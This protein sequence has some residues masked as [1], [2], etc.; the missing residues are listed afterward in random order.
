VKRLVVLAG[1]WAAAT[2]QAAYEPL[3]MPDPSRRWAVTLHTRGEFD[4]NINTAP[5]NERSSWKGVVEPELRVN[6]PLDQT[7]VGFRYG[8]RAVYFEN[9][10]GDP[11]D[12]EHRT[13]L[14]LAHTINPRLQLDLREQLR[15]GIEPELVEQRAAGDQLFRRRQG[16]YLYNSLEG[17]VSYNFTRRWTAALRGGWDHWDYE[18]TQ[19]SINDR[20]IYR[21]SLAMN[22]SID[23]RTTAGVGYQFYHVDYDVPGPNDRRN[24]DAHIAYLSAVRRFNPQLSGQANVGVELREFGDGASDIGPWLDTSLTYNYGPQ[25]AAT[26]GFRYSITSTEVGTFRSADSADIL[27]Q[28]THRLTAKWVV[29]GT[30]TF[31]L[32]H[33][34]NPVVPGVSEDLTEETLSLAVSTRYQ[35]TRWLSADLRYS[36]DQVTSDIA[37][38]E[39]TRNRISLGCRL[40]Y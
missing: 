33:F 25:S 11:V 6:V 24:S 28:I 31:S 21:G 37:G 36:F 14:T 13:D 10:S 32:D 2:T 19:A 29:S 4:D 15:L 23:R 3:K 38:R 20:D 8:Y 35:F 5:S 22:Y 40:V 27:V 1:L 18:E 17:G 9:R 39:F 34:S 7:F 16:D 26:L 30:S 12:Q